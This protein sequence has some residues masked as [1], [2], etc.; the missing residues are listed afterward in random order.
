M[1][2]GHCSFDKRTAQRFGT[3]GILI[4]ILKFVFIGAGFS[5][6]LTGIAVIVGV[7]SD[8]IICLPRINSI[9]IIVIKI[10]ANVNGE[11]GD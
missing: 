9:A 8:L 10:L 5:A 4:G 7:E 1:S 11:H 6:G 2:I 3:D